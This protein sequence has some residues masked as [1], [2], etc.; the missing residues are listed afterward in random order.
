LT[1]PGLSHIVLSFSDGDVMTRNQDALK[2]T[3]KRCGK[4]CYAV[5][6]SITEEDI[7]RWRQQGRMDIVDAMEQFELVWAGDTIISLKNNRS[8]ST[9]PFLMNTGE[10]RT[11]TIYEDSP[12]VCREFLPGSSEMCSQFR[13][14]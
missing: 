2:V 11:C 3:C 9:C 4:C 5:P 14:P 8:V 10:S 6:A 1:H 7:N 13:K 12:R